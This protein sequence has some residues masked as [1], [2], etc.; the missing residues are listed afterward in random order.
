MKVMGVTGMP[1][2]GKG[3]VAGVGR[4]LGFKIIRMGDVIREEAQKNN[5]DIGETAIELRKEYGNFVVAEK[6]VEKIKLDESD[7]KSK[8][9]LI[10]GIRS[11]YEVEIFKENFKDFKVVAVNSTPETRFNRLINRKRADDSV[12]KSEFEKRDKR[13]LKF[14][15][16]DVIATA[17]YMVT[18]EGS[19]KRFKKIIRSILTNE[20][21]N[22]S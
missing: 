18:N 13:E 21:Q 15:I 3:L 12:I 9:F 17:D 14:G 8:L 2:S 19:I 11:P 16:G 20:L 22:A 10:E 1:G 5:A 7:N 4:S 6:C